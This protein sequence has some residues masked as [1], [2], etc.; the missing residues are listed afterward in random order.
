MGG[1]VPKRWRSVWCILRAIHV[2]AA[3]AGEPRI[4]NSTHTALARLESMRDR[5][6]HTR[7]SPRHH[8]GGTLHV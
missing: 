4:S 3:F 6:R 5:S 2:S 1:A 7:F 8:L